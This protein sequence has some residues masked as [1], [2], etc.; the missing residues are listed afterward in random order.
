MTAHR[1]ATDLT[2]TMLIEPGT[3]STAQFK[4]KEQVGASFSLALMQQAQQRG[5]QALREIFAALTPGISE[6]E[7]VQLGKQILQAQGAE[8]LWH[9][10]IIRFGANTIKT[11]DQP[12]DR[13]VRLAADDIVFIDIGPVF[14]GHEADVGAT[15][16]LGQD[17]EKQRC[18]DAAALI[19]QQVRQRWLDLGLTGAALYQYAEQLCSAL[20]YQLNLAIKGHR[21]CDFPHKLYQGG[22]LGDFSGQPRPG[23][24]VL[25]IQLKHP[26]LPF[27]AFYE[28]VLL[29][30]DTE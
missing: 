6:A 23:V 5:W 25:E 13:T 9:P 30:T 24:W 29:E 12:S 7:A 16:V 18:A 27:G 1:S 3:N 19:F 10:V 20:G 4:G 8:R 11:Y 28:D 15:F 26:S 14:A 17:E 21:L 2:N 22:N